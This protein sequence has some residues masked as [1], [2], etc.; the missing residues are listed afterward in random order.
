MSFRGAL[1][2]GGG[3]VR[4]GQKQGRAEDHTGDS[5][6]PSGYEKGLLGALPSQGWLCQAWLAH[7]RETGESTTGA[8]PV[9]PEASPSA[10][11]VAV[12]KVL[13]QDNLGWGRDRP[14]T[15]AQAPLSPAVQLYTPG[16]SCAEQITS[17]PKL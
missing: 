13:I 9:V 10:C 11:P 17:F 2:W 1:G 4:A 12:T 14:E 7:Q 16:P 5:V 15:Q 3:G 6:L 8:Q